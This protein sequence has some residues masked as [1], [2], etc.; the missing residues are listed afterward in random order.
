MCHCSNIYHVYNNNY[1]FDILIC[2][3]PLCKNL[4]LAHFTRL[5][6]S[7]RSSHIHKTDWT[8]PT[9]SLLCLGFLIAKYTVWWWWMFLKANLEI[10]IHVNIVVSLLLFVYFMYIYSCSV[11]CC[12][13]VYLFIIFI[14]LVF[15]IILSNTPICKQYNNCVVLFL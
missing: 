6:A 2:L 4:F 14:M 3:Q 7:E 13:F 10:S 9:H 12:V 8:S 15:V 1:S 5:F 11:C